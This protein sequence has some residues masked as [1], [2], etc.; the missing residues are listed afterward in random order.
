MTS[1][2]TGLSSVATEAVPPRDAPVGTG[3]S[4]SRIVGA[5]ALVLT[6]TGLLYGLVISPPDGQQ[7]NAARLLYIHVPSAVLA[8]LAFGITAF[9]SIMVLWRKTEA[10]DLLAGAAA[11]IGVI[12]TGICLATGMLW[13]RPIWGVYW[14][15]DARLTTTALLFVLYVGYLALRRALAGSPKAA[16]WSAIAGI[17]AA[18]DIPIV[19]K[20]A[21]WWVTLHQGQTVRL[22]GESEIGG[23]MLFSLMVMLLA[24]LVGFVWLLI[25]RFRVAF[26]AARVDEHGLDEAI[27]AR[28]AEAAPG[29][30]RAPVPTEVS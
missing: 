15:W 16:R 14:T 10:W 20:S 6:A 17:V 7:S 22:L 5:V 12:F 27:A 9:A 11:E 29:A 3:S 23:T 18:I 1:I 4:G 19:H 28:R 8:Y 26:L 13:G 24:G 25:V 2:D 21:D 30:G